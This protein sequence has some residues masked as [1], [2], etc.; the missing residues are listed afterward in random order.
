M[1]K[2]FP[3][4]IEPEGS[5][6]CSREPNFSQRIR[7]CPRYCV[8]FRNMQVLYGEGLSAPSDPQAVGYPRGLIQYI[9]S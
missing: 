5:L 8:T 9:Y 3:G 2:K 6:P 4:F 1:V 7:P